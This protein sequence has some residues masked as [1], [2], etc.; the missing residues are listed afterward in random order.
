MFMRKDV[1]VNLPMC[2]RCFPDET[3][4]YRAFMHGGKA[5][6]SI[7]LGKPS[8]SDLPIFSTMSF[9]IFSAIS[10]IFWGNFGNVFISS[11]FSMCL[12]TS[13]LSS[14]ATSVFVM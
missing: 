9:F 11:F 4:L 6:L 1:N 8:I 14:L 2:D 7:F 13:S 5:V 12:R 3:A 10:V